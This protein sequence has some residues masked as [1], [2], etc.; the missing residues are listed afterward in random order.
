MFGAK[1]VLPGPHLDPVSLLDLFEHEQVTCSR[2]VPTIWLG[3]SRRSTSSRE[4]WRLEPGLRMVVGGSAA[5][6]A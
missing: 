6:E 1:Q 5:P 4:R 3:I 2:G